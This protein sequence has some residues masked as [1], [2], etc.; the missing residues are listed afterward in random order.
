MLLMVAWFMAVVA[1]SPD[2]TGEL[3]AIDK[4]VIQKYVIL[5]TAPRQQGVDDRGSRSWTV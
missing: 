4:K 1:K 2:T 5:A 3:S